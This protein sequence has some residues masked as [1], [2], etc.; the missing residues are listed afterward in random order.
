[1]FYNGTP[2][3]DDATS[4]GFVNDG[5]EVG[6]HVTSNCANWTPASLATFYSQQIAQFHVERP[7]VPPL[8]TNRTHCIVWSDY[9]TQAKVELANGIRFDTNYYFYPPNWVQNRPGLFIGSAMPMRFADFDGSTIDVYQAATQM[10]DESEQTYPFIN[11]LFDR[12]GPLGYSVFGEHAHGPATDSRRMRPWRRVARACRSSASKWNWLDGRNGSFGSLF[13]RR[14]T[15]FDQ[16]REG[17]TAGDAADTGA[18]R[19]ARRYHATG[20]R[21]VFRPY[22]RASYAFFTGPLGL[23]PRPTPCRTTLRS[24]PA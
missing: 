16:R 18:R 2:G 20:P 9:V 7:S 12:A 22:H 15:H 21:G 11:T 6:L 5:F 23:M 14:D 10:T 17:R 8:R 13:Q 24:L 3:M 1:M 4:L 19:A